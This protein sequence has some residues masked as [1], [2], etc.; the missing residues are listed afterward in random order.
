MTGELLYL[1]G[2][3]GAGKS[4][5]MAEL[6]G[7]CDRVPVA[8]P[9]RHELLAVDGRLVGAE[10]GGR[11]HAFSG[12]DV[13]PMNVNPAACRWV[14]CVDV[15]LLLAEGD[16]LANRR[17]LLAA[18][19]AGYRVTIAHLDPDAEELQR[20]HAERGAAQDERWRRGRATKV[21]RLSAYAA[22]HHRLLTLG[23]GSPAALACELRELMPVLKELP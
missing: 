6:T 21:R 2:A 4:T 8:L 23:G 1:I 13:L 20:R 7:G 5:L 11:R 22:E 12:T 14:G 16:R 10:I 9:L 3:P 17:F 19:D 18:D 15:P